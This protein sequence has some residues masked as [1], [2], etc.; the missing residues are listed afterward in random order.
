MPIYLVERTFIAVD[1][2]NIPGSEDSE[3]VHRR[4]AENNLQAG[5]RWVYSYVNSAKRKV[6]CL[7]KAPNPEAVRRAAGLNDLPVDRISEVRKLFSG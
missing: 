5:V 1:S 4:F 2:F 7:Y 6:F 3:E